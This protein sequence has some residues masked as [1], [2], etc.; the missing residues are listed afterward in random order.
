[1]TENES[2]LISLH[3]VVNHLRDARAILGGLGYG[4]QTDDDIAVLIEHLEFDIGE[5]ENEIG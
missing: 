4:W 2:K 3:I 1:M 5:L